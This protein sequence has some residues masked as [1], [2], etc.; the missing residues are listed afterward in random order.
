MNLRKAQGGKHYTGLRHIANVQHKY[1][2]V[3]NSIFIFFTFTIQ[4]TQHTRNPITEMFA[5]KGYGMFVKTHNAR[6]LKA[7]SKPDAR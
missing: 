4:C 6:L 7:I 1:T 3:K 5:S 2:A